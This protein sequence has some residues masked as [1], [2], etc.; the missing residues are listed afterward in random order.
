MVKIVSEVIPGGS[1]E[2]EN[3]SFMGK[4]TSCISCGGILFYQ[5][6]TL[7]EGTKHATDT[8]IYCAQCGELQSGMFDDPFEELDEKMQAKP[9]VEEAE[10]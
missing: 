5:R 4:I 8:E 10:D 2:Q 6:V 7:I 3:P 9:K 1:I